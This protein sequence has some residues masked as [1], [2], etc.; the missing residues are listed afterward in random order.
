ML[1]AVEISDLERCLGKWANQIG[2]AWSGEDGPG[3]AID[4]KTLHSSGDEEHPAL[5]LLSA[6]SHELGVG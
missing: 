3:I 6:F 5:H 1:A 4:G 2:Q